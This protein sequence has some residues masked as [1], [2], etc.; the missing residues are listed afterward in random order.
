MKTWG[1]THIANMKFSSFEGTHAQKRENLYTL[2]HILKSSR[3]KNGQTIVRRMGIAFRERLSKRSRKGKS[4]S[5]Q[6]HEVRLNRV[7]SKC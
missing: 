7:T 3:R 6:V 5:D 4:D 2:V 1:L